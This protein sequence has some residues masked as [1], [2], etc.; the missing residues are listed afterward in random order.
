MSAAQASASHVRWFNIALRELVGVS[1]NREQR[2]A[3]CS[4]LFGAPIVSTKYLTTGQIN[5]F[6]RVLGEQREELE[7]FIGQVLLQENQ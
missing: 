6:A 3:L 7:H 2:L 4:A 5:A 1:L